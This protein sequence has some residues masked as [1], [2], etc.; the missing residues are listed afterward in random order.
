[1]SARRRLFNRRRIVIGLVDER[2]AVGA[3]TW[4]AVCSHDEVKAPEDQR[5]YYEDRNEPPVQHM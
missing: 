4:A 2:A 1:M 3:N 5:E